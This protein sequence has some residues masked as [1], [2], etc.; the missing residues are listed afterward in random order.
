[1]SMPTEIAYSE[2]FQPNLSSL[3]RNY[4]NIIETSKF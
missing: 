3:D 1:M 2:W 4:Q